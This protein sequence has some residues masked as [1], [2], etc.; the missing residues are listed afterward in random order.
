MEGQEAEA[1]LRASGLRVTRPRE[2]AYRAVRA[3]P[4]ASADDVLQ[5][6]RAEL[7]NASAQSVYNALHD[8]ADAHLVRRI[9][10]AGHPGRYELRIGDNHHHLVC[11]ACGLVTDVDCVADD[12][13]CLHPDDDHGFRVDAAE[14]TFWGLCAD[15]SA[16]AGGQGPA[17]PGRSGAGR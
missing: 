13:P 1:V 12:A 5:A 8:F 3:M 6:V 9:V 14:I 4:H 17:A 2:A 7:P 16:P 15:C 11:R 10:P